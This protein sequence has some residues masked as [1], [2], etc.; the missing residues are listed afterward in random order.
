MPKYVA[1]CTVERYDEGF[2]EIVTARPT[3][4]VVAEDRQDAIDRV[5]Q[6]IKLNYG[7]GVK[8]V[9]VEVLNEINGGE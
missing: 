2:D 8:S 9:K 1:H 5:T 4:P 3:E 7:S 6:R